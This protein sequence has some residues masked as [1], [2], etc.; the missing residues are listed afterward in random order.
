MSSPETSALATPGSGLGVYYPLQPSLPSQLAPFGRLVTRGYADRLW[1]GESLALETH[2]VLAYL[3]GQGINPALGMGVSLMPLYNPFQAALGARSLAALSG[4][5]LISVFG[6]SKPSF[7]AA[8]RGAPYASPLGAAR[9][10][11]SAV[12]RLLDGQLTD[13]R[14]KYV[15]TRAQLPPGPVTPHVDVGLGV[16][17]SGMARV[18][19]ETA[20]VALTWM[21]PLPYL[22]RELLP[23]LT[24]VRVVSVVHVLVVRPGLDVDEVV[25]R[26][27]HGHTREGHYKAMLTAAGLGPIADGPS[28]A[29][30]LVEHGVVLAGSPQTVADEI[31]HYWTA[32]I[33]EVVLNPTVLE[34][35]G[36]E[37]ALRDLLEITEVCRS[38]GR[39]R[40]S[41]T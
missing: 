6:T 7:V 21:A 25:G 24:G 31:E 4:K 41:D 12:R 32:G 29:R 1:L 20:D 3:A 8:L 37:A 33:D 18:A 30:A 2:Q 19:A 35:E 23:V 39:A 38:R 17:R 26:A 9:E 40:E 22:R 13:T 5:R 36:P 28:S 11:V 15:H 14:G 16:L 27:T 10:Y 34:V